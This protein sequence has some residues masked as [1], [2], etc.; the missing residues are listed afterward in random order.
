MELRLC[1][2]LARD[3]AKWRRSCVVLLATS[4]RG[5]A[6]PGRGKGGDDVTKLTRQKKI[7]KTHVVDSAATNGQ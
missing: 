2:A 6:T 1:G 3:E 5:E 7:K 4:T